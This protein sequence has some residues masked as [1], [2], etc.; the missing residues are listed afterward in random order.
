MDR[1]AFQ[2]R[3][4][5]A[6]GAIERGTM[7]DE[8]ERDAY[9]AL[10]ARGLFPLT[11][12]Q[13]HR[14][15]TFRA[16]LPVAD[17]ALGLRILGD[18]LDAGLPVARA[19][20]TF[21]ELAPRGWAPA[22]PT[23]REAVREGRTLASALAEAPVHIPPLVIGIAR[24]GEAG[25]GIGPAIKRAA[26][27]TESTAAMRSAVR[28]A[29]IYP[30]ILAVAGTGAIGVLV[31]VVLP[32]FGKILADLGQTLPRSTRLVIEGSTAARQ[33][34][35]PGLLGL[36]V[37]ILS[38]RAWIQTDAGRESWHRFLLKLPLIGGVRTAATTALAT[39]SL[40]TLLESGVPLRQA[41]TFSARSSGDVAVERRLLAARDRITA[42]QS[43]AA[44]LRATG[45]L[46]PVAVRLIDA[47]EQS[48]RVAE[49]LAHAA[50]LE[51]ARADR[52][53]H[54]AVKVLEPALI[55]VFSGIVG[56]VA[57]ALLQAVYSVRP[58]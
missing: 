23:L 44:A 37:F 10:S 25:A 12:R 36:I 9:R 11:I 34:F 48:G 17:L 47:G 16:R 42:G 18:L 5:N 13:R 26:D 8:S 20:A 54:A 58:S 2:Y 40:S 6:A 50:K 4:L 33:G 29:L 31:G 52:L 55:L 35:V 19:L 39:S 57:A 14:R 21:E 49:M 27:I 22:I 28:S 46:T 15:D 45:G 56:F 43:I 38:V 24:A 1:Y 30:T 51:Q 3:A 7:V 53:T 41:L 32:R